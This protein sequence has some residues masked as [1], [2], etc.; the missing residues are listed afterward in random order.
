MAGF[1]FKKYFARVA[2]YLIY[3][4][5]ILLLFV[6]IFSLTSGKDVSFDVLFR[7]DSKCQMAGFLIFFSFVY[8]FFGFVKKRVYLNSSF[9]NEREKILN[10][11]FSANF[12]V[13]AEDGKK[14]TLRHKSPFIRFMR[15]FEDEIVIDFNDNPIILSGL[16]RDVYRFARSIEYATR[17]SNRD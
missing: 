15:M 13:I 10:I 3:L 16:R 1:D 4:L 6:T 14:I 5:I 12:V 8:P 17:E 2:K 11:L 7:H 9:E